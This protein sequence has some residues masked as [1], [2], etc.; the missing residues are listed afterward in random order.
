MKLKVIKDKLGIYALRIN[1]CYN[2]D[3][4]TNFEIIFEI[5]TFHDSL[6]LC[7]IIFNK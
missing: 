4:N 6:K 5:I 2:R 3:S 7:I 1:K